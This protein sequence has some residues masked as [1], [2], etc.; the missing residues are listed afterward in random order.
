[1]PYYLL[2]TNLHCNY[3][4]KET[5]TLKWATGAHKNSRMLD[6]D[7]ELEKVLLCGTVEYKFRH[8]FKQR[9]WQT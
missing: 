5:T 8:S 2:K 9:N 3:F 6:R 7:G 4:L 1:M